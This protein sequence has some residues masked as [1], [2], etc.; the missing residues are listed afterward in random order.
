[1]SI[2]S[3]FFKP[4]K[5]MAKPNTKHVK[6]G[7]YTIT[8]HA[9]NRVAQFNRDIKKKDMVQNFLG[10]SDISKVYKH[11]DGTMQYD[12]VNKS[13]RTITYITQKKNKV[14][15]IRKFHNDKKG[16][17]EAYKNFREMKHEHKTK[18]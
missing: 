8:S 3:W 10:K 17:K 1:M 15:T 18:K 7:K 12:R 9:Q 5:E 16:I 2:I 6:I 4:I 14:K 11:P 13:N